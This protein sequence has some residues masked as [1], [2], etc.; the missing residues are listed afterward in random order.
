MPALTYKFIPQY[1]VEPYA[2][3]SDQVAPIYQILISILAFLA[4]ATVVFM[5][6]KHM[7]DNRPPQDPKAI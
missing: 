1:G 5:W 7:K 4:V 6:L 3:K 2:D